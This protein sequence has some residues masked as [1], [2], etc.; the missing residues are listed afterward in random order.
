[1][2][3]LLGVDPGQRRVGVA[4]SDEAGVIATPLTTIDRESED[5]S[6]RLETI[7]EKR[8]V[9][10]II[11]GFPEPLNTSE[12]ERTRQVDQFIEDVIEPLAVDFESVSERYSTKQATQRKRDR[13]N[14]GEAG[15]DEAAAMILEWYLN[16]NKHTDSNTSEYS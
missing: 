10:K 11:V 15:D 2:G 7:I 8:D 9:S 16:S 12:N 14:G 4:V 3:R 1:M 6:R 13:E 5:A